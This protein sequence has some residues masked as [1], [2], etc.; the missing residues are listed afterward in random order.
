MGWADRAA[1]W[2][3]VVLGAGGFGAA[4]TSNALHT[5]ANVWVTAPL[6]GAKPTWGSHG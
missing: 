6:D 2:D 4:H 5:L 3:G 1:D